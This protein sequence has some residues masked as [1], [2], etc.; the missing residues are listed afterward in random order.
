MTTLHQDARLA[1]PHSLAT[2]TADRPDQA[3]LI[4]EREAAASA[5]IEAE[6]ARL[7]NRH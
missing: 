7:P 3:A 1:L 5:R 2:A 4:R 6:L